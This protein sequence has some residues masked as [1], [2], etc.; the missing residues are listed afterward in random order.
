[1]PTASRCAVSGIMLV[2]NRG[3]REAE[4]GVAGKPLERRSTAPM[5]TI[6]T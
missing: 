4:S 2:M 3:L 1:M 6:G 5:Y